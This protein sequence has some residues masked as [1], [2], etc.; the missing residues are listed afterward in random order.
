MFIEHLLAVAHALI[1]AVSD[2]LVGHVLLLRFATW[3]FEGA[4]LPKEAARGYAIIQGRNGNDLSSLSGQDRT[5]TPPNRPLRPPGVAHFVLELLVSVPIQSAL[6]Y[7]TYG[8][9]AF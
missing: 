1:Y 8:G 9:T 5:S 7:I 3:N 2:F 6:I 4:F